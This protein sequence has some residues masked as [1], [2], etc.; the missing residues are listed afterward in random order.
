MQRGKPELK[1]TGFYIALVLVIYALVG[2]LSNDIYLPGRRTSGVHL[3]YEAV[4]PALLG[5]VLFALT[6]PLVHFRK[7]VWLDRTRRALQIGAIL[8][9]SLSFYFIINPSGKK[10]ATTEECQATFSRLAAFTQEVSSDGHIEKFLQERGS[11]CHSAPILKSYHA[12]IARAQK[13]ADVNRCHGESEM[14][15]KRK[16]AT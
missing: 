8:S 7:S 3:H 1:A 6:F 15:F 16:N 11:R 13:P 4:P 9:M 5:I 12:C 14:L 10:L 2:A